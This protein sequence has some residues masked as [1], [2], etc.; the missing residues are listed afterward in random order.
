M[1]VGTQ[2]RDPSQFCS[3]HSCMHHRLSSFTT[4]LCTIIMR[5]T[6]TEY[7][8]VISVYR[9]VAESDLLEA[10]CRVGNGCQIS[11]RRRLLARSLGGI[12]RL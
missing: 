10:N 5:V 7:S 9:H 12:Q 3:S 4:L 6:R 2:R 8:T 11:R 1:A